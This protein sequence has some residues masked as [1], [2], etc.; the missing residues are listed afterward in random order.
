M[1]NESD[2][3]SFIGLICM[4][5][6]KRSK[7]KSS[8]VKLVDVVAVGLQIGCKEYI[9]QHKTQKICF[10]EI[11]APKSIPQNIACFSLDSMIF[12]HFLIPALVR[13]ILEKIS[14]R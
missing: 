9:Q 14:H 3:L 4:K 1:K 10:V 7:L 8:R 6:N 12:L 13:Y 11:Q 2:H 5:K